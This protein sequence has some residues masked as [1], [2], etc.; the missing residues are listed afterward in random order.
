[1]QQILKIVLQ[2]V[3]FSKKTAKKTLK[4]TAWK[5]EFLRMILSCKSEFDYCYF[6][7][8]LWQKKT[9]LSAP[10]NINEAKMVV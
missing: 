9:N 2:K 3:V 1:V 5:T 7:L 10:K 6:F 4:K 8:K